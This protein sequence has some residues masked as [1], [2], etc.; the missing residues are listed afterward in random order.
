MSSDRSS[1]P[2]ESFAHL[3]AL[4]RQGDRSAMNELFGFR[5]ERLMAIATRRF[6]RSI[7]SRMGP[8]D[9][10]QE[11]LASACKHFHTFRANTLDEF[12]I[13]LWKILLH[14]I[15]RFVRKV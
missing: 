3:L 6:P 14:T 15:A 10:V 5:Q 11:T 12:S 2:A 13:W 7:Q 9:A 8:E 1:A 4:A